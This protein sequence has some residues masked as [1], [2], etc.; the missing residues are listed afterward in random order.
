M[1][2]TVLITGA[3]RGIGSACAELFAENNYNIIINYL[4]CEEKAKNLENK[5]KKTG[6]NA[7]CFKADVSDSK[8][9]Q[10]MIDTAE[11]VFGSVNVLINNAGIMQYGLLQDLKEE[12]WDRIFSINVKGVFNVT[13]AVL[14]HMIKNKSGKIINISSI[15]GITGASCEVA[16]SS[17]KAAIIGFT[18]ALAKELGPCNI[19]INCIAP[20]VIET[21]MLKRLSLEEKN[22]LKQETPLNKIGEPKDIANAAL[23]LASENSKFFTG[24]IIS[25]NGGFLI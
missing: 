25:P 2:K 6:I 12:E 20:G 21:D 8:A 23:F 15:W 14:P 10:N 4:N 3:S 5:L 1:K 24:Q 9:V 13:K 19:N 17:T 7:I 11:K 18:K 16:Y 22:I